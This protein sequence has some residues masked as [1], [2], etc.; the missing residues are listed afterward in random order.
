MAESIEGLSDQHLLCR[1]I[2]HSWRPYDV[3]MQRRPRRCIK[4]ILRCR[5]CGA[6]RTQ[7]LDH[8]YLIESSSYQYPDGYIVKGHGPMTKAVRAQVRS[9]TTRS[10]RRQPKAG[11]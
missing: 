5:D 6:K 9:M 4:R 11:S 8:D 10:W 7:V 3:I 2:G 1:D